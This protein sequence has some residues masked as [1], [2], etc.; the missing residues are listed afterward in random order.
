MAAPPWPAAGGMVSKFGTKRLVVI[1]FVL[2]AL[3]AGRCTFAK[4]PFRSCISPR[5]LGAWA[6]GSY[7]SRCNGDEHSDCFREEKRATAMG[8]FKLSTP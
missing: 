4:K 2:G 3:A 1:G 5:E 7:L 6:G 8:F